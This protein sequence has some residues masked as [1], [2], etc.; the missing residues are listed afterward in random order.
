MCR[1]CELYSPV[2]RSRNQ[3]QVES[4]S[5]QEKSGGRGRSRPSRTRTERLD[6]A[7]AAGEPPG[8]QLGQGSES[9]A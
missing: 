2:A 5:L 9:L 8:A 3:N 7:G 6:D 4:H 1:L